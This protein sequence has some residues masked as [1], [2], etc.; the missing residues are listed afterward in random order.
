M[1]GPMFF[2]IG[3]FFKHGES[4]NFLGMW[5]VWVEQKYRRGR[6]KLKMCEVMLVTGRVVT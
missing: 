1:R 2:C 5:W 3:V 4:Q 6:V